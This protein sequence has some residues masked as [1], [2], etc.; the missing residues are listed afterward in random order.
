MY[1]LHGLHPSEWFVDQLD[2]RIRA[3]QAEQAGQSTG[4]R[5]EED[6]PKG[7]STDQPL[8]SVMGKIGAAIN[9]VGAPSQGK[10]PGGFRAAV[11]PVPLR[12]W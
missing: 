5:S 11:P 10:A 6:G 7:D 12:G 3:E 9:R 8:K 4:A 1:A 2:R